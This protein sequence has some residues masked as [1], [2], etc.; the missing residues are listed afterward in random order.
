MIRIGTVRH[1]YTEGER[2]LCD[3]LIDGA[4][5][6][7]LILIYPLHLRMRVVRG[8]RL[9]VVR[10]AG[11]DVQLLALPFEFAR[12]T[13]QLVI[14]PGAGSKV[15]VGTLGG[16]FES[17]ATLADLQAH[18]DWAREH[19]HSAP[20]GA[21]GIPTPQPPTPAGTRTVEGK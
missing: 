19:A 7:E 4:V 11:N 18:V 3:A 10:L 15:Q 2:V 20:G 9:L 21:T 17:L 5:E 8:T 16:A 1:T 13:E 12:A 6:R 14:H